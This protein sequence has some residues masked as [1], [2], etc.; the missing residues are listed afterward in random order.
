MVHLTKKR[1]LTVAEIFDYDSTCILEDGRIAF[2]AWM[3]PQLFDK[4]NKEGYL[5]CFTVNDDGDTSL[6]YIKTNTPAIPCNVA[7]EVK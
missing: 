1:N 2:C 4:V 5:F 3:E 6:E 7:I